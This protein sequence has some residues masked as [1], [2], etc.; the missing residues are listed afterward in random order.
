MK[1]GA[2][3]QFNKGQGFYAFGAFAIAALIPPALALNNHAWGAAFYLLGF[4]A[5]RLLSPA[6]FRRMGGVF[7]IAVS[8]MLYLVSLVSIHAELRIRGALEV[9][10]VLYTLALA[11]FLLLEVRKAYL[12]NAFGPR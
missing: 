2:E 3:E 11:T 4:A 7:W 5:H 10:I 1:A 6:R 8:S 12:E 9:C